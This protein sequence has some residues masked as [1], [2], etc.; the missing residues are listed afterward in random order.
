VHPRIP[1]VTD[2]FA[3]PLAPETLKNERVADK[4]EADPPP[5]IFCRERVVNLS[6]TRWI[7]AFSLVVNDMFSCISNFRA[8]RLLCCTRVR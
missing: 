1:H 5:A 3:K 2:I 8:F 4:I 6:G 7:T